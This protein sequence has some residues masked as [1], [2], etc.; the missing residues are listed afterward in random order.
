MYQNS[1]GSQAKGRYDDRQMFSRPL[2]FE[3]EFDHNRNIAG[4]GLGLVACSGPNTS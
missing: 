1:S 3:Y 2:P 4:R